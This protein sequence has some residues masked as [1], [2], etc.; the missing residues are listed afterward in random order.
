LGSLFNFQPLGGGNTPMG[1]FLSENPKN[2]GYYINV[3][4]MISF[5]PDMSRGV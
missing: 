5:T 2:T 1:N 3:T 4:R